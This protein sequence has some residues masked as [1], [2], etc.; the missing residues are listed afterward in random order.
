MFSVQFENCRRQRIV[1]MSGQMSAWASP[2]SSLWKGVGVVVYLI[3]V[4]QTLEGM[5]TFDSVGGYP[6]P[7]C[8]PNN[9]WGRWHI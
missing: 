2:A 6:I 1:F 7:W 8:L 4:K 3:R 5:Y 9:P